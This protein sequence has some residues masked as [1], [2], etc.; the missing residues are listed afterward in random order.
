M[1]WRRSRAPRSTSPSGSGATRGCARTPQKGASRSLARRRLGV[2][3]ASRAALT[4]K[5]A[6]SSAGR[7]VG[8]DAIG[9][10]CSDRRSAPAEDAASVEHRENPSSVEEAPR[11]QRR[12]GPH[13]G[14]RTPRYPGRLRSSRPPPTDKT[15]PQRREGPRIPGRFCRLD[16]PHTDQRRPQRT[17][18]STAATQHTAAM[19]QPR[20]LSRPSSRSHR[21][22]RR[23]ANRAR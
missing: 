10:L 18:R 16:A 1:R 5:C 17:S 11:S 15:R 21:R 9:P 13:P 8:R 12:A 2:T 23:S 14:I 3:P 20:A 22:S 6:P 4:E 19:R 7:R